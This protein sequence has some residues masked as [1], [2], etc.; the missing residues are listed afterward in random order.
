MRIVPGLLGACLLLTAC[1]EPGPSAPPPTVT[2]TA[3][4]SPPSVEPA[5]LAWLDGF[6]SVIHDYR[7]RNNAEVAPGTA[8]PGSVEEVQKTLSQ[9]LG[10]I[11]DRTGEVVD[12]LK[13]LP[14][15]PEPLAETVRQAFVKKY[16]TSHNRARDAKTALDGAKPGDVASQD[17][18]M[19]ALEQAQLDLDGTYDPVAPLAESQELLTAAA[20][21]PGCKA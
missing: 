7:K 13:A 17:P 18:A 3:P 11:A 5:T 6:C 19:K 14:P 2:V 21:A 10:G 16:T 1:S 20:S 12:R 9:E 8:E 15:A 4:V